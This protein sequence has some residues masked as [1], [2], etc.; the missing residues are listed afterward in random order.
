MKGLII[1]DA[2]LSVN[3][4]HLQFVLRLYFSD[5]FEDVHEEPYDRERVAL[6][7]PVSV[8]SFGLFFCASIKVK[9]TFP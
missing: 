8:Y 1:I 6:A 7:S 9:D 3:T 4:G 5:V 2:S